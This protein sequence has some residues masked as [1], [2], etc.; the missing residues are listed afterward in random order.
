M[1]KTKQKVIKR[2][3]I[4]HKALFRTVS[5]LLVILTSVFVIK[6]LSIGI[7]GLKHIVSLCGILFLVEAFLLFVLNKRFKVVIK[8]PF[9]VIAV[10][11]ICVFSYGSYSLEAT[12]RFAMKIAENIS[13]EEKY[14]VYV[15][16]SSGQSSMDGLTASKLGI[17]DSKGKTLEEAVR[18]LKKKASFEEEKR[19]DDLGALF[20]DCTDGKIDVIL[21][22]STLEEIASEEYADLFY[23][24]KSIGEVSVKTKANVKKSNVDVTNDPFLVY[25][26]GIDTY[27]SIANIS[28]SDVNILVA[29]NP[30]NNKV[31]L[32]NTPRDYYV[33]LHSK[34]AFDK[35]TH[36]GNYGIE[37]SIT[38]LE[39]L[40][41]TDIDFYVKLNFSS[42]IKI[43]DT[44]GGIT[45]ESK[46]NFAYD[47]HSFHKGKN[48]LNG[49]AALAFS[50]SRKELPLGDISRGENQEAVIKGLIDKVTS[51]SIITK[52]K[53]L[54]DTLGN[55]V[56]T[57]MSDVEM[58]ALA[59]MQLASNPT[60]TV[61]T[62]NARGSDAYKTT[63][64]AGKTKLYVMDPDETSVNEV[65]QALNEIL[66]EN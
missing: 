14:F 41:H 13:Y 3:P 42:L 45:V 39:D 37:E 29:V 50:R 32:V 65:I 58:F 23:Q 44:L 12:T 25:I 7:L 20:E 21:L 16:N 55:S 48:T 30:K 60:W 59:K 51:P 2:K 31:L 5:I 11:L 1:E 6:L 4:K 35:L 36:A 40:Y 33:K 57:N 9:L 54:L 46:Y 24:L 62:K 22:S 63:Y 8:V 47:G 66:E 61:E 38:T 28:R 52:Y 56:V 49:S 17:F 15:V 19:Y 18:L 34:K 64:S 10:L 26:S 53:S 43:V 27:G